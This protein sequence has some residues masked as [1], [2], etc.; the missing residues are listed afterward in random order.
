MSAR[1]ERIRDLFLEALDLPEEERV[2]WLRGACGDDQSLLTEV[3][4]L[5]RVETEGFLRSP[6]LA[7]DPAELVGHSL[8]PFELLEVLGR[9][10][11]GVVF[12]ARQASPVREVAVKVLRAFAG[13]EGARR[14][15][16]EIRAAAKLDHPG[17]VRVITAG[18]D[19]ETR[20]YAMDLVRGTSL[21]DA[22][23]SVAGDG[24]AALSDDEVARVMI[25]LLEALQHAHDRNVVHRDVKPSNVLLDGEG[26]VRLTDFGLARDLDHTGVSRS[27]QVAGTVAYMSPE[28]ARSLKDTVDWRTDV[29]S[30]GAVM[31]ALLAGR[32]PHAGD[33]SAAVLASILEREPRSLAAVRPG[34]DRELVTICGAALRRRP[35]ERYATAHAM[36]EDLRRWRRRERV[37]GRKLT[38]RERLRRARPSRRA[39]LLAVPAAAALGGAG[40]WGVSRWLKTRRRFVPVTL[41][42]GP[43][44][45]GAVLLY[46]PASG[47]GDVGEVEELGRY[48][49]AGDTVQVPEGRGRL[50]AVVGD[51]WVSFDRLYDGEL[52]VEGRP[53]GPASGSAWATVPGGDA[54]ISM[55]IN[56]ATGPLDRAGV[57]VASFAV[58]RA[59]VPHGALR[60]EYVARG[61]WSAPSVE[62]RLIDEVARSEGPRL[63]NWDRL[64]ATFVTMVQARRFA[65][66]G[67]LRLLTSGEWQR[68]LVGNGAEWIAQAKSEGFHVGDVDASL[69]SSRQA[70][71][72]TFSERAKVVDDPAFRQGP[73]GLYHVFGNVSEWTSSPL[74]LSGAEGLALVPM[75][76]IRGAAWFFPEEPTPKRIQDSLSFMSMNSSDWSV[77]FRCAKDLQPPT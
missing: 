10:G 46:Q 8:G 20:W 56:A 25:E 1:D 39:A 57:E 76:A 4:G 51:R 42:L 55:R 48:G 40:T 44:D 49:R 26:R 29:Y 43:E 68:A 3:L 50:T 21:A 69:D 37:V 38:P 41:T 52:S 7:T 66:W 67:G 2:E 36:A 61:M 72:E 53:S 45:E 28:Q 5:L 16:V 74:E 9:G 13:E 35:D 58:Q 47:F 32:P 71:A 11:M 34:V 12:R 18:T 24:A 70:N 60:E 22:V 31:Y 33:S 64:P 54:E 75:A 73:L 27:A 30:A 62:Q 6:V 63:N 23:E 59:C 15:E 65:E 14:F 19:G 17:V 77:G